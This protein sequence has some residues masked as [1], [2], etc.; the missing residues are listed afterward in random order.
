MNKKH[1][2]LIR[3]KNISYPSGFIIGYFK[4]G[5]LYC[6]YTRSIISHN[7]I[8]QVIKELI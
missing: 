6:Q 7:D 5:F 8:I 4:K 3:V 2:F 1:Y